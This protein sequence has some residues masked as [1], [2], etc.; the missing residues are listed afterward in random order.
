MQILAIKGKS[1][2]DSTCIFLDEIIHTLQKK[3]AFVDILDSYCEEEYEALRNSLTGKHYDILLTI[4]GMILEKNSSL[5]KL[6]LRDNTIYCTILM[7]H[8]YIHHFRL[9]NRYQRLLVYSP[10]YFHIEYLNSYYPH[11]WC[12]GF[13]PHAGCQTEH[14]VPYDERTIT[15]SFLG[16]YLS[17]AAAKLRFSEYPEKMQ[18]LFREVA[19]FLLEH[20][21]FP[22]EAGIS[23]V[24]QH[25]NI[26]I[27]E[28]EFA[29]V[30]AEFRPVD[31]YIRAY[32]RDLV[33]RTITS[34]EIPVDVY[35]D[36]WNAFSGSNIPALRIHPRID[37]K[38][39][40]DITGNSKISLNVMPWFKNGSHDRVYTA[41][42]CGAV[43]LTDPSIYFEAECSDRENL[44]FYH[45]DELDKLPSI[46]H[47]I[48]NN[49]QGKNYAKTIAENG[50]HFAQEKHTWK[51]RGEELYND[52]LSLL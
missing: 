31:T 6:L 25:Y 50:R 32:F 22:L 35:G 5:G 1:Q 23:K 39:S 18:F 45:L 21:S 4:N 48:L 17:P 42:L 49:D 3:G 46:I 24:F 11:I 8:P 13:L 41:M 33:I 14:P 27:P 28:H 20:R 47:S 43:C 34:A 26:R 51:N 44:I 7:D 36:G 37:F 38:E 30:V 12:K 29:T 10:D 16:S 19:H 9:Q 15:V 40:L 2:Y 52:F